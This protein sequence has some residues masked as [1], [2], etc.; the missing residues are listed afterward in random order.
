TFE[1]G[2]GRSSLTNAPTLAEFGVAHLRGSSTLGYAKGSFFLEIQDEFRDDKAVEL[3]GLPEESDWIL[4]APNNFEPALFHNPLAHQLA[5]DQGEYASRTR[6][7]EVYLKDD[8]F[9]GPITPQDYNGIYVLEERIK[10]DRNRID[11]APLEPEHKVIPEVTGGYVLSIDRGVPGEIAF[12]AGGASM[13]WIDPDGNEMTNAVRMPQVNYI[14]NYFNSFNTALQNNTTWTNPLTGYAAYIDVNSWVRRHVHEVVTHNIDALRLSG[15]FYKDRNEKIEYG[16]PWDYDRTQGSTD[17]RD[18]NPFTWRSTVGDLGTDYFNFSP[19]WNRLF[20]AP[21]FWQAWIDKY[22][23]LRDGPLSLNNISNRIEQL[24]AQIRPAHSRELTRWNIAPRSGN[25]T[26]GGFT[27]NFGTNGYE[28]EV[29]WKHFWYSNRLHFINTQLLA[30]PNLSFPGGQVATGFSFTISPA[31]KLGSSLIYTLDGTDPRASGGSTALGALSNNGPVTIT[32]T[33]NLRVFARSWNPSHANLTGANRPPISSRWSGPVQTSFYTHIPPLRITEIMYHPPPSTN[34][35]SDEDFEYIE[36][37]NI[38]GTPLNIRDY[39]ISGG[40]DFVFPNLVLQGGERAVVVRNR[41]AFQQRYG[42]GVVIAGEYTNVLSMIDGTRD[43]NSLDNAGERLVLE[44]RLGEPILDFSYDD[45]WYPVTDGFG[46]SLVI[47]NDQADPATWDLASSWRPSGELNGSPGT[48]GQPRSFPP[49]VINEVLTHSD[50]PPPTDT[51]ELA[52]L[53]GSPANIGGWFLTDDFRVPKK[54]RIPDGTT[55]AAN[56]FLLFN[57]SHFNAGPNPFSLSSL[58]EEVYLFSGDGTNLTGYVH[59]FDFGAAQNGRTFGRHIISTGTDQYPPQ[60]TP[61]LGSA[62]SGPLV[63]PIVISEIHYHPPDIRNGPI[64]LDNDFDEYIELQ[65]TA[66][67]SVPLY[68]PVRPA[69]TWR[70][71]DAVDFEFPAT[72]VM[73]PA[74]GF[75][76]IV[77]FDPADNQKLATFRSRNSVS[78]SVP[79]FGPFRGKL[80]NS[81]EAVELERPDVPEPPGPPNFGLVPYLLVER[82]RY[83]DTPPWPGAADGIGPSLQRVDRF[84]YGND[85]AN[86][87]AAAPTPGGEY[88]G[89]VPPAITQQPANQTVVAGNDA[90]FG[91]IATGANL[92]Y[93]WRFNGDVLTGERS[94]TL[95]L[96]NVQPNQQGNYDVV[97]MNPTGSRISSNAFLTV[98]IPAMVINHPTNIVLRNGSTNEATFGQTTNNAIFS[99]TAFSSRPISYQWFY[100]SNTIPNATNT[101][102]TISNANLTHNGDYHCVMTDAISSVRSEVANLTVAVVPFIKRQPQPITALVGEPVTLSVEHGGTAPFAFRWRRSGVNVFPT[103]AGYIYSRLLTFPSV[104]T[105]NA[106]TYTVI[107]TN[108]ANSQPGVLSSNAVLVVLVDTDGDKAPDVWE[109]QFG[110][111]PNDGTDGDMDFDGDG[112][113]NADEF[114]AGTDPKDPNSYLRVDLTLAGDATISF[115]A[116]SNKTYVVEYNDGLSNSGWRQLSEIFARGATRTETVVDP[117]FEPSRFYRVVTPIRQ[118]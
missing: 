9:I 3:L 114:R 11:I 75:V 32:V 115:M 74:G 14:R 64:A 12:S 4:Y 80:D 8:T 36:F 100:N 81:S 19:W 21:D 43:T 63:G 56:G 27:F 13:N 16:P 31:P 60:I 59:G 37:R 33:T 47:V 94:A 48:P 55:V 17:G 65:N 83:A 69:N 109:S 105:N 95:Q 39:K 61:T 72:N 30:R 93:Q 85:P 88:G 44:G 1:P 77:S 18:F 79:I 107:I 40:V 68:D 103:N 29:R 67:G 54:Y 78:P 52:N 15:Y 102:Y 70:L 116:M 41:A 82:V 91:V 5:R 51:V 86:W 34:S 66:D 98:L 113:S 23:E 7:V 45:E 20:Q 90:A 24:A 58:G 57:E 96:P 53:S 2:V 73:I 117:D 84:A 101:T 46:F 87:V 49:V 112:A 89:G 35:F 104:Q 6:F 22:Q 26:G 38:S 25:Q 110:F 97:V 118:D 62:N 28:N 76:V 71:R 10:R 42:T 111:L 92:S 99:V 106:G 50:P 108:V